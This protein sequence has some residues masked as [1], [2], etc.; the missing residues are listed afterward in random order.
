MANI[1]PQN[2]KAI[3][4]DKETEHAISRLKDFFQTS[5]STQLNLTRVTAP[6]F[7]EAGKGL[8]DDLN[9]V[10]RAVSFPVK[11]MNE[12]KLEIVQSLAKWKRVKVTELKLNENFGIYTD[13]NAIRPDDNMDNIHSIYVDQWD[14]EMRINPS[15][16]TVEKLKSVV[17]KIYATLKQ[18][19]FFIY[20]NY[21][22]IKPCLPE[23]ITF[24][25]ADDLAKQFPDKTDKEREA[26]VVKKY[27]A[28]FLM[29]IGGKL[30]D[31]KP[32]DGRAP[33]YD[34]WST[35]HEDGH[36][37]LNGDILVWNPVL[38]IPFELSSMGVR[39]SPESLLNQLQ[40]RN[41]M[42]R[43]ELAFHKMLLNGELYQ[44]LGGGIG[45]SR[46]CMY[47]LRKAHIGEI[48]VSSWPESMIAECKQNGIN[49]L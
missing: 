35:K 6:L 9:G 17:E 34:D 45:Q 3:L 40:E 44:T 39:V 36:M 12:K 33:D 13:M 43:K 7:V 27:G 30:C 4:N 37:G 18:T 21:P 46:L 5:L 47:F 8:N 28:V 22:Q 48:Q 14:W 11:N 20:D 31:G 19:E 26:E 25:W 16:R 41:C 49:L 10:E 15:D 29:G 2:Y 32:H 42:E 24:L 1:Y 23:N 38:N